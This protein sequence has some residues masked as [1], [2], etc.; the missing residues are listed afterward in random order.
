MIYFN[1]VDSSFTGFT[2]LEGEKVQLVVLL[3]CHIVID[4]VEH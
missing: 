3:I 4:T 2:F 1:D